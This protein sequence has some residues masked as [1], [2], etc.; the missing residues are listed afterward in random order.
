MRTFIPAFSASL[1]LIL[2]IGCQSQKAAVNGESEFG[3]AAANPPAVVYV[4]DFTL[5]PDII[6]SDPGMLSG[7]SGPASRVG[8][9]LSGSSDDRASRAR[10]LVDLMA[11]SL[12]ND[13]AK[14]KI[15]AA[16]LMPDSPVPTQGWLVRGEFSVVDEGN[17][18]RRS[19]V[20]MGQGET[21]IQ[22]RSCIDDLS[23]G[24]PGPMYQVTTDANSGKAVGGGATLAFGPYGAAVHFVKAGKDVEK[25]VKETASQIADLIVRRVAQ[26]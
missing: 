8:S 20:G 6:K 7:R 12:V 26:P 15:R 11:K 17:R 14:A 23:Q 22:V 19:V 18:L 4:A 21:D 13:L 24:P 1:A 3:S 25:N 2:L 10:Q 5:P 16:R 9:R